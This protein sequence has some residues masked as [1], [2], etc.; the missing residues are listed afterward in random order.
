MPDTKPIVVA[1][2]QPGS[3]KRVFTPE[4][5][6]CLNEFAQVVHLGREANFTSEQMAEALTSAEGLLT[7]W[8]TPKVTATMARQAPHLKVIAHSAGSLRPVVEREVLDLGI[9]VTSAAGEIGKAVAEF[10]IGMILTGMRLLWRSDR[11]LQASREW[12]S[13]SPPDELAWELAG[14]TVGV[15]S[16]SR[17]GQMVSR[18]LTAL[19]AKV[20]AYDPYAPDSTFAICGA[21]KATLEQLFE[22]ATVVT[23]HAPV[24]DETKKMVGADLLRRLANGALIVNTARGILFDEQALAAELVCGRLRAAMDVTDPEP[25]AKDSPLYGLPNVL[26]TPHQAGQSLESLRRQGLVAV[27][28]IRQALSGQQ[29]AN[30][31][32]GRQWDI[33]A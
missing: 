26:I 32:T 29:L 27:E 21:R 7:C 31:V 20:I 30:S 8:G 19:D 14:R 1:A 17:I 22:Q 3:R 2:V 25:P 4:A 11:L 18:K 16:L 10:T 33:L 13:A 6:A 24:T 5:E 9:Q 12:K 28:D 15:V 23:M